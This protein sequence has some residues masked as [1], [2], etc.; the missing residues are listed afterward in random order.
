MI[1][2]IFLVLIFIGGFVILKKFIKVHRNIKEETDELLSQIQVVLTN[3]EQYELIYSGSLSILRKKIDYDG[4]VKYS[5]LKSL[6]N[7]SKEEFIEYLLKKDILNDFGS[8]VVQNRDGYLIEEDGNY[9]ILSIQE[10]GIKIKSK[11]F[12]NKN[13]LAIYFG[14]QIYESFMSDLNNDGTHK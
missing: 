14:K 12:N 11:K 4:M 13:E 9:F 6:I 8:E 10:R 2:I 3:D 7:V 5:S 1:Y